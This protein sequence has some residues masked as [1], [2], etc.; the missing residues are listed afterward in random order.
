MLVSG[1]L[2]TDMRSIRPK[3]HGAVALESG[4]AYS[5]IST[6]RPAHQRRL[7]RNNPH[8]SFAACSELD[9]LCVRPAFDPVSGTLARQ[10]DV[11]RRDDR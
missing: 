1:S 2:I 11:N 4:V 6:D 7:L 9:R 3:F 10:Q 5:T 8:T